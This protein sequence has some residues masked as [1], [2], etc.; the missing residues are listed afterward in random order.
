MDFDRLGFVPY[1]PAAP[2]TLEV[3]GHPK[4]YTPPESPPGSTE[5]AGKGASAPLSPRGGRHRWD[6]LRAAFATRIG[7]PLLHQGCRSQEGSE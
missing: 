7:G 6:E 4:L 2:K 5:E 3:R 1:H